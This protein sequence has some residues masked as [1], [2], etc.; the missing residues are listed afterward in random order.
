MKR[1]PGSSGSI[2][3]F[4]ILPLSFL[5]DCLNKYCQ[6]SIVSAQLSWHVSRAV[7]SILGSGPKS[8]QTTGWVTGRQVVTELINVYKTS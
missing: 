7:V 2:L 1:L 3:A 5:P 4:Q 6:N 8:L